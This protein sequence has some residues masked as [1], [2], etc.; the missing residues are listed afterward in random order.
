M[1]AVS[2]AVAASCIV[3][4]AILLLSWTTYFAQLNSTA[5]DFTLRLAGPISPISPT[6]IVAIDEDSIDRI[7]PWPWSRDK[8]ARLIDRVQSGSPKT[9]AVDLLLDD[10]KSD[11]EDLALAGAIANAPSIVLAAR[12][13]GTGGAERW[14]LPN[15]L[16]VQRHVRLGHVHAD[17]D[18]DFINRRLFSVK[19][20][21]GRAIPAL[22]FEALRSAGL[23]NDN[24]VLR[25]ETL[26]IRFVGDH[27]SFRHIPAWQ[28]L[29]GGADAS[30][31]KDRIVLIG[32]TAEGLGD[33]WPSPFATSGQKI[34]GVEVHANAIET[35]FS[36]RAIREAPDLLTLAGLAAMIALLWWADRR[37][38]GRRFYVMAVL[39]GP[40]LLAFSWLL[41]KR[42]NFWL[43]F[44]PFW[45][46]LALVVPGLEVAK[47]VRVNRDLD[48]KIQR[49]SGWLAALN[50]YGDKTSR[51]GR[52]DL[53]GTERRNAR[54]KLDAVDFFNEELMRFLSFNNAI[55]G[56]IEDVIIVSDPAGRV[57]YQ[58]AAAKRVEGYRDDPGP[59][60]EY[61]SKL[62][63]GRP[64]DGHFSKV[65][66]SNEP[67]A[68]DFLP[69]RNG[70]NFY[71][72]TLSP[73][74]GAGLVLSLHDAT[75]Q[76]ELNQAKSDMVSL[77]SHELRT[78]LTSIRGYSDMLLKYD[79]V[80]EKGKEF[81]GTI[82]D[83]SQ[84]LNQLIQSF[85]D[86]ATIESGRQS[87]SKTE[88]EIAPVLNDML[89]IMGP[90]AAQ[91]EIA[92]E[93]PPDLNGM[94]VSADRLLLYQALSNLVTNAVKYSPAGTTV[95]VGAASGRGRVRFCVAD[96]GCGIPADETSKIFEKFYRRSNKETREQSG[97][98]LG[99]AFVK[100]VATRHGGDV[101]VESQVG[102]GSVFT[103][104]I[105]D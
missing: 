35:L 81:L 40:A 34:S 79:L 24:G 10:R 46:A 53:F 42:F 39:I 75:A 80:Q 49:L 4:V 9:I 32:S 94:R 16:F 25:A 20:G 12:L 96:E 97:F 86:I 70:R 58:N 28:L 99:L 48:S 44:P 67:L 6:I 104:S 36:G 103:L 43:P 68:L 66:T 100:E 71:N 51:A 7:G 59:A 30:P 22:S 54:W 73:I 27:H 29:D 69:A 47:L 5:Y 72:V 13:D 102:K 98:G 50:V 76:F 55:L 93:L 38:E 85:L 101:V 52:P 41:M 11:E 95:R 21:A 64:F 15:A 33:Q 17:P 84:R 89:T 87:I 83:E 77:V 14:R 61:V 45:A 92:I 65:R 88:F 82:I 56:A 57:V 78:P 62:L 23:A 2:G 63:D 19:I 8:L 105:P 26:N 60:P 31:F 37:F 18:F 90:V 74:A 3:A 91:K 1:K